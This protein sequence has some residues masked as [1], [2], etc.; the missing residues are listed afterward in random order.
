MP[1]YIHLVITLTGEKN[2]SSV[3][4]SFKGYI[5]KRISEVKI[6]REKPWQVGYF[7]HRIRK[8]ER[9]K[10]ILYCCF[11]NPYRAGLVKKK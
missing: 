1:D 9:F 11:Q 8:N 4:Q 10:Q 6:S 5:Y 3:M 2:L 7:D